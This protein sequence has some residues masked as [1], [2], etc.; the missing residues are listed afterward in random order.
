[1]TYVVTLVAAESL[2]EE[3][4]QKLELLLPEAQH[5]WL[6]QGR[7]LDVFFEVEAAGRIRTLLEGAPLDY[8][9]QKV[10]HRRKKL[11]ISDMD[12]TIIGQECIDEM[13]AL[14]GLKGE[15]SAITERAMRGE[16]DFSASLTARVGL[17]KGLPVALLQ[18]VWEEVITLNAGAR[19]LVQ[20]MRA[21]GAY[22]MLVSGGFTFFSK[23]VAEA[24]G[25]EAHF[26]NELM[27]ENKILVGHVRPPILHREAKAEL[28]QQAM[29]SRGIAMEDTLAV[30]DGAN[31]AAMIEAAGLGVAYYAKP[32]LRTL[33][34]ASVQHTDLT[35]LL[36]FQG[37]KEEEFV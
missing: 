37:Y 20:T 35:T 16:L 28:L 34:D 4:L 12:S 17:L 5:R 1:M 3:I 31:D 14:A 11:L 2:P 24:A 9:V 36:Y 30:G 32:A 7:A 22:T 25:F 23:K 15:V 19:T 27:I 26:A 18:R 13:A 6:A 29:T 8:T 33:A 10:A 21:N